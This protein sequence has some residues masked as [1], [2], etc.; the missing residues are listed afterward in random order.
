[1]PK[2]A[3]PNVATTPAGLLATGVNKIEPPP[4]ALALNVV[5]LTAVLWIGFVPCGAFK[6]ARFA[7]FQFCIACAVLALPVVAVPELLA[8]FLV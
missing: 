2:A 1:M 3:V 5:P 6:R 4:A 7:A 8:T